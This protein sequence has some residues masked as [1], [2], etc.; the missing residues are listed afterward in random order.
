MSFLLAPF[1]VTYFLVVFLM[2]NLH[3][4]IPDFRL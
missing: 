1:L 4:S 2:R 3:V